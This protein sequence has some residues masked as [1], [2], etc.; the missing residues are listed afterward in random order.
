MATIK[1]QN[2]IDKIECT[3][4]LADVNMPIDPILR[5][6]KG[7]ATITFVIPEHAVK[8]YTE[9]DGTAFCGR[10]IHILPAKIEKLDDDGDEGKIYLSI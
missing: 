8:A 5:Q 10:M 6:P 4:P 3:G 7:F 9:L 2:Y 1:N